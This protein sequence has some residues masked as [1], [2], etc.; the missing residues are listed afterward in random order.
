MAQS[1]QHCCP[2]CDKLPA[3]DR[4]E[5][6]TDRPM[7]SY[8]L[9][10]DRLVIP[11]VK[12]RPISCC[13]KWYNAPFYDSGAKYFEAIRDVLLFYAPNSDWIRDF[14]EVGEMKVGRETVY[15]DWSATDTGPNEEDDDEG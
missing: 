3:P 5:Y 4:Y 13:G 10:G 2:K 14:I 12:Y 11:I 8:L 15:L 6:Q 9:D 1:N 7:A